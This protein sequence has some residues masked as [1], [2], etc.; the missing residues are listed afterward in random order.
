MHTRINKQVYSFLSHCETCEKYVWKLHAKYRDNFQTQKAVARNAQATFPSDDVT[1]HP[2]QSNQV[3]V[4]KHVMDGFTQLNF[5]QPGICSLTV[6][7]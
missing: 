4:H 2:L 6:L 7:H 5:V 1:N 3:H